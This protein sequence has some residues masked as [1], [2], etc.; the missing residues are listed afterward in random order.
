MQERN[1]VHR[2]HLQNEKVPTSSYIQVFI[3]TNFNEKENSMLNHLQSMSTTLLVNGSLYCI[4]LFPLC[5]PFPDTLHL[6][7]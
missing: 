2:I 4:I 6:V 5:E 1:R 7:K 3:L